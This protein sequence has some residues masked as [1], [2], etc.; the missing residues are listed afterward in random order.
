[1]SSDEETGKKKTAEMAA[2]RGTS[3][4]CALQ[5]QSVKLSDDMIYYDIMPYA[6]IYPKHPSHNL[7]T[8][9]GYKPIK[10][11]AGRWTGKSAKVMEDRRR[12]IWELKTMDNAMTRRELI[13]RPLQNNDA[14]M[15]TSCASD[16]CI[17][18][19]IVSLL[20][21]IACHVWRSDHECSLYSSRSCFSNWS[22]A[23]SW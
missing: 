11:H 13:L 4:V 9:E 5:G 8:A 1:M 22:S 23:G 14:P 18:A 19:L 21:P 16:P 10:P 6:D 7:T 3:Q 2:A 17:T 20:S 12:D 15:L